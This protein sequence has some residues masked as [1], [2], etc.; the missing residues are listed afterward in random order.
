MTD[1]EQRRLELGTIVKVT[2]GTVEIGNMCVQPH[3][4]VTVAGSTI[5]DD[6]T[7]DQMCVVVADVIDTIDPGGIFVTEARRKARNLANGLR[8]SGSTPEVRYTL[9]HT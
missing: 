8:Y 9:V 6:M 3:I 4:L 2:T 1:D 5:P 7:Y